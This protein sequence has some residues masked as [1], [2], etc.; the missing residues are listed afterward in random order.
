MSE[1]NE[2]T[3]GTRG[4]PYGSKAAEEMIRDRLKKLEGMGYPDALA[5]PSDADA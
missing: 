2:T 1:G 3:L 5:E 4:L